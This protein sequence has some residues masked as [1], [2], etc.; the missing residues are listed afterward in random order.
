G[1]SGLPWKRKPSCLAPDLIAIKSRCRYPDRPTE[2]MTDP[3]RM[4]FP[5]ALSA[6]LNRPF[7]AGA[8]QTLVQPFSAHNRCELG[9]KGLRQFGWRVGALQMGRPL[10]GGPWRRAR[11]GHLFAYPHLSI[12][13]ASAGRP[14][15]DLA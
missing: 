3:T 14:Q 5:F 7:A 11:S 6:P 1:E 9:L 10:R 8:W 2:H 4:G 12:T 13:S 15:A